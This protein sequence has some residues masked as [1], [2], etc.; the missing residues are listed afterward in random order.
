MPLPGLLLDLDIALYNYPYLLTYL[1]EEN[2]CWVSS[3]DRKRPVCNRY[4]ST[5]TGRNYSIGSDIADEITEKF[6]KM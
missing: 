5:I 1:H 2:I 3:L 4:I 6:D